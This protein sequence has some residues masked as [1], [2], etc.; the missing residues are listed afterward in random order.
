MGPR[1]VDVPLAERRAVSPGEA[2]GLLG[3][4][5]GSVFKL[6][7]SKKLRSRLVG[8][9]RLIPATALTELLGEETEETADI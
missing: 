2:A 1:K 3:I 4:G 9:R 7:R 6:L 8:R 5:Y